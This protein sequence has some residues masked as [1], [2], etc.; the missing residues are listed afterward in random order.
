MRPEPIARRVLAELIRLHTRQ[1]VAIK[2]LCDRSME[3][4]PE[5]RYT[6]NITE[7]GNLSTKLRAL[8]RRSGLCHQSGQCYRV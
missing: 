4:F 7:D 2:D 3:D 1:G 8:A 5:M 6:F